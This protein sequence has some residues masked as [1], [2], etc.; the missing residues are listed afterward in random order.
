[1]LEERN[2]LIEQQSVIAPEAFEIKAKDYEKKLQNYQS[3][4]QNK[5]R[6]LEGILQNARNEIL[7]KVKP[8]LED[9]SKELGVTVI[10]EKNSV[11]LSATNMDITDEVI[12]KLNK[13]LP[14]IKVSLD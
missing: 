13:E 2:K 4:K 1:M 14:K 6:K 5:L 11:L 9:L 12:K 3:E 10:L 7:E 8:I